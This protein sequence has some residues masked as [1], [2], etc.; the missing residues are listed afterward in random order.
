VSAEYVRGLNGMGFRN[1][2]AE[3]L[4][5]ARIY[6]VS[7]E[8]I[9]YVREERGLTDLDLEEIMKKYNIIKP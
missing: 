1:V 2:P 4:V 8:Y 5:K 9:R 7:L 6:G 3:Q